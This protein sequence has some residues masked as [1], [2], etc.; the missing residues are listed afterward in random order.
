MAA[1]PTSEQIPHTPGIGS[2]DA[3]AVVLGHELGH[4]LP[5]LDLEEA[6][7]IKEIENVVRDKYHM[8]PRTTHHGDPLVS[9]PAEKE[10]FENFMKKMSDCDCQKALSDQLNSK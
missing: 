4:A 9:N 10:R 6:E 8:P 1:L 3:A 7:T 2:D 5:P